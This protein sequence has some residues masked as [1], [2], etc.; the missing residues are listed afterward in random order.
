MGLYHTHMEIQGVEDVPICVHYIAVPFR[1]GSTDG[2]HGPKLEPDEDAHIEI[3]RI[4]GPDP[5]RDVELTTA[6]EAA[7]E[8]EISDWL[9]GRYDPPEPERYHNE[10]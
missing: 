9:H 2:W 4:E 6:Q 8:E 3:E 10:N 1:A 5:N 7:M